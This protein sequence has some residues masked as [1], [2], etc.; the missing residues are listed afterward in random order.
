MRKFLPNSHS[1]QSK[2]FFILFFILIGLTGLIRFWNLGSVPHGM[3]WD[4]AA[5]GYNGYAVIT[6]RR[7]EWLQKIPVSFQSFGDYKAPAAIYINGLFTTV[8]GMKLW[9]VRLPFA[10]A[11][12]VAV[13]AFGWVIY[14]LADK[15]D[16][17]WQTLLGVLLLTTAPWHVHYSRIGFESGLALSFFLLGWACIIFC[18]QNF[19]RLKYFPKIG[20]FSATVLLWTATFYT[21]HSAK[22]FMPIFLLWFAW[23]ERV[24]ISKNWKWALIG[25]F[26]A[27]LL[28][29]PLINN[30]IYGHGAERAGVLITNRGLGIIETSKVFF[31]NLIAHFNPGWL[32]FGETDSLRHGSGRYGVLSGVSALLFLVAVFSLLMDLFKKDRKPGVLANYGLVIL[33]AGLV[34]SALS[35][36]LVPH[37]NRALFALPGFILLILFATKQLIIWLQPHIGK[38]IAFRTVVGMIVVLEVFFFAAYWHDYQTRYARLSAGDFQDGYL[39]AFNYALEYERGLNGR[40]QVDKIIVSDT[41]GQPYIFALFVRKTSPIAYRGG[42]LYKYEFSSS[43]S[44]SD[45]LRHNTLVISTPQRGIDPNQATHLVHGS[46]GEVRFVI[47]YTGAANE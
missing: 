11:G 45:L 26:S 18:I 35:A 24:W 4:E 2:L 47:N 33:L 10:L 36:E 1:F 13:V 31:Q 7:D 12:V 19:S 29:L 23:S 44:G 17:V 38:D 5:I 16:Q 3:T 6:T 30:T 34:P 42:S 9:V 25:C 22:I 8:L 21:Y 27:L 14:Q 43:V 46:D 20:S 15:R 37:S 39:E 32:A 28:L 41:Y 40:P